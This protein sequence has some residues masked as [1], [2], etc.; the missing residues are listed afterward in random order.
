VKVPTSISSPATFSTMSPASD[1]SEVNYA[2]LFSTSS[3]FQYR[4]KRRQFLKEVA[5]S[6]SSL[7]FFDRYMATKLQSRSYSTE[8]MDFKTPHSKGVEVG[9]CSPPK[10]EISS[11]FLVD[12]EADT[13]I[14][15]DSQQPDE[16]DLTYTRM[17]HSES[18]PDSPNLLELLNNS[19]T[20]SNILRNASTNALGVAEKKELDDSMNM[21]AFNSQNDTTI[22]F[23]SQTVD[24]LLGGELAVKR[25]LGYF[26]KKMSPQKAVAS[27]DVSD[28][29]SVSNLSNHYYSNN[30]HTHFN[31]NPEEASVDNFSSSESTNTSIR[32]QSIQYYMSKLNPLSHNS[33]KMKYKSRLLSE[34]PNSDLDMSAYLQQND[35]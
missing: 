23:G 32:R 24:D 16:D 2:N 9:K 10:P 3:E 35:T 29:F 34:L 27:E 17:F 33:N 4:N 8:S 25:S 7:S 31:N 11:P 19:E 12:D 22:L 14:M 18:S 26:I 1:S 30:L 13:A 21:A 28:S 6:D 5:S 20:T 15:F